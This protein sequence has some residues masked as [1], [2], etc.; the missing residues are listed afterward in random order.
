MQVISETIQEFNGVRYYRMGGPGGYY[1]NNGKLLHRAVWEDAHG[2]IPPKHHIHH[3]D[4][5]RSNNCLSNLEC[6][7]AG[8]HVAYHGRVSPRTPS[9]QAIDAATKW[10]QDPANR[11]AISDAAKKGWSQRTPTT[12]TCIQCGEAFLAFNPR[13]GMCSQSCR[14]RNHLGQVGGPNRRVPKTR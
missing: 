1:K 5:D 14:K 4:H 9:Q 11:E 13:S 3:I 8:E 10:H 6:V 7:P 2:S 12:Y